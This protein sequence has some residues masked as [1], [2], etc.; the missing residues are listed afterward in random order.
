M[1]R[2]WGRCPYCGESVIVEV[3][4]REPGKIVEHSC[5]ARSCEYPSCLVTELKEEM[6][7]LAD[8]KWHCPSHGLLL[9]ARHL[10]A[11]YRAEM[12]QSNFQQ[13]NKQLATQYAVLSRIARQYK[14]PVLVTN[15][16]YD[17]GEGVELTSRMIAR[18]WSKALI[19]LKKG[20]KPGH[21]VA[22]VRKHRSL[23]EDRKIA[24]QIV[25]KGMEEVPL[26]L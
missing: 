15:Q 18:Y 14:I 26:H 10:V 8:G 4:E 11:L 19:E 20:E 22:F 3:T 6:V 24:F 17:K 5:E 12:D 7:Q 9:A 2:T 16:V 13:L 21:R 25:E 1:R 23:P